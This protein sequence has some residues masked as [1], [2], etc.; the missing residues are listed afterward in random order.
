M[1]DQPT[2]DHDLQEYLALAK[3]LAY[4]A[5]P[6]MKKYFTTR[7]DDVADHTWKPDDSLVTV[8]D[9]EINRLVIERIEAKYPDHSIDGEEEKSRKDSSFVWVCDPID[10]TNIFSRGIPFSVF[11]LALCIDGVPVVGVVY[12]P[13]LDKLYHAVHG[14]GAFIN[15][16]PIRVNDTPLGS[17]S[18]MNIDWWPGAGYDSMGVFHPFA[19]EKR[20]YTWTAGSTTHSAVMV[21]DG[22][23]VA[24]VFPGTK[25]KN[26]DVAAAA[27][28][29]REAGGKVT[30]LFGADQRYDQDIN[31]CILSNGVVHDELVQLFA[32]KLTN[33][34]A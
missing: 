25:G 34:R 7:R 1:T 31:G 10:G 15:D 18:F 14:G 4:E 8:A 16:E 30:D 33:N 21:A 26:V 27:V 13:Y 29:V 28:I 5:G 20:I 19:M 22:H 2:P 3:S 24:S 12:D 17:R 6:I 23:I 11:S 32:S 9:T